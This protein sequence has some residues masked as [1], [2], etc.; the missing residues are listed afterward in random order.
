MGIEM[1]FKDDIKNILLSVNA[2]SADTARWAEAPHA[3]AYRRGYQAALCAVALACGISPGQV[4]IRFNIERPESLLSSE[5][6][7]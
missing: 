3:V 2:S 1:W 7:G 5:V 6:N 4:C